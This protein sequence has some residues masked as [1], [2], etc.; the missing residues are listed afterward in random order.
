MSS[1]FRIPMM[2]L[3]RVELSQQLF[4]WIFEVFLRTFDLDDLIIQA[5]SLQ[6]DTG[7]DSP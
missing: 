1:L 5:F 2:R 4:D 7:K 6:A 3:Y